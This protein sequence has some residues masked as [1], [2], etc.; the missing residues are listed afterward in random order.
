MMHGQT[1][2]KFFQR[3]MHIAVLREQTGTKSFK[4][5]AS[6][7]VLQMTLQF[8]LVTT[9]NEVGFP[10]LQLQPIQHNISTQSKFLFTWLFKDFSRMLLA[11]ALWCLG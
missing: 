1:N 11:R 5:N 2:I 10:G 7:M 3:K 8:F 9:K 4:S 6:G